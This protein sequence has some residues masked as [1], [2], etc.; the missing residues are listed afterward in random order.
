MHAAD[1]GPTAG[2]GAQADAPATLEKATFA[3][4]C[5]WCTEAVFQQLR[6]V[7]S[8]RSGYTGGHVQN[9]TYEDVCNGTT[10]HAE[11]IELT[12]DP[13]AVSYKDLL[14]VFWKTH[15]PTTLNRQGNDVGDQYRS[16]VFYHND[17]Q[18]QL[19]EHYRSELDR[20]KAFGAPI[21]TEIVPASAFYPA[22]SYHQN[23]YRTNPR[24]P[25][26]AAIIRPKVDK[27]KQVFQD[28][29]K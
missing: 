24:Q 26:C 10:G 19:A 13:R 14:E 6:G 8:V 1:P 9:P 2:A 16:A 15:D 17:A 20:A 18:R 25:Y 7:V 4:G 27:V 3:S 5:F 23:Y 21:V 22:E 12:F 29:L 28:R 11:A